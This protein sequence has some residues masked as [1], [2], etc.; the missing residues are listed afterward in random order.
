MDLSKI[1]AISGKSGLF[2]IVSQTR[3]GLIVESLS[4]GKKMP[5]FATHRSSVLEDISMF[6]YTED[7]PLKNVLWSIHQKEEGKNASLDLKADANQLH[8]YFES[9]LPDFDR[10][11]V[12]PSDIKKV[13]QW[14]NQL[15]EHD[16][17]SEPVEEEQEEPLEDADKTADK[18]E[19]P[20]ATTKCLTD[21]KRSLTSPGWLPIFIILNQENLIFPLIPF[22]NV[23]VFV[24]PCWAW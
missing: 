15:I 11:R 10:E 5:V 2:K 24:L 18:E 12:Y 13:L 20:K 7:V 19:K 21:F 6:T 14:Y 22:L 3:G 9:V 17:I 4:D 16:L 23:K 8:D 1:M